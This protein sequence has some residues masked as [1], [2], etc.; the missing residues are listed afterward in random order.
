MVYWAL[1]YVAGMNIIPNLQLRK[2][3]YRLSNLTCSD[4][5]KQVQTHLYQYLSLNYFALLPYIPILMFCWFFK[6]Y[7]SVL[8]IAW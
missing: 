7:K 6:K 4:W 1:F 5:Q 2:L 8:L 3:R